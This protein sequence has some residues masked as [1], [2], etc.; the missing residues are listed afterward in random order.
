MIGQVILMMETLN[1]VSHHKVLI[2]LKK[3]FI[4]LEVLILIKILKFTLFI[5]KLMEITL[6][7]NK[8]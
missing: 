3:C 1:L 7:E 2:A 8:N 6:Q 4:Q 5:E